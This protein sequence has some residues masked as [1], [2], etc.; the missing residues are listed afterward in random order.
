MSDNPRNKKILT[1]TQQDMSLSQLYG[2][3]IIVFGPHA[4][5]D[6]RNFVR[7]QLLY[8]PLLTKRTPAKK[9][10]S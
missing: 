8:D 1:P 3:T 4:A 7:T 10:E 5:T 6:Q 2:S 9:Y